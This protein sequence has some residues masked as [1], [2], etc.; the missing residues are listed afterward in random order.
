MSQMTDT[1]YGARGPGRSAHKPSSASLNAASCALAQDVIMSFD[2]NAAAQLS[3]TNRAWRQAAPNVPRLHY[4]LAT[5]S[6]LRLPHAQGSW[7]CRDDNA[8]VWH[9]RKGQANGADTPHYLALLLTIGTQA[10]PHFIGVLTGVS[11]RRS[12]DV[13]YLLR[14]AQVPAAKCT[15]VLVNYMPTSAIATDLRG[16]R[17]SRYAEQHGPHKPVAHAAF[18]GACH[19]Q[20]PC[21]PG[22]CPRSHPNLQ[23]TGGPSPDFWP[24]MIAPW[25]CGLTG[26]AIRALPACRQSA[27][28]PVTSNAC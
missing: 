20:N 11:A 13:D 17:A 8:A 9:A 21:K 1:V 14:A 26:S 4:V 22:P 10:D 16:W 6:A 28:G 27:S 19:R 7:W 12:S 5:T 3:R 2:L 23:A 15:A 24:A 18:G 25:C